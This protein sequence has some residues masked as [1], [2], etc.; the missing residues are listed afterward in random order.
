MASDTITSLTITEK[1]STYANEN[2][3]REYTRFTDTVE[4]PTDIIRTK[5]KEATEKLKRD[6]FISTRLEF[7]SKDSNDRYFIHRRWLANAYGEEVAHGVVTPRD[8]RVWEAD[9]TS[10]VSSA[11]FLQ[12]GR[13]NRLIY[14]IPQE[15]ITVVDSTNGYFKL[16][17]GYPTS[18]RR[19]FVDYWSVGKRLSEIETEL[20]NACCCWATIQLL[21]QYKKTH[22]LKNG[23]VS[24]SQGGRSIQRNESDFDALVRQWYNEYHSKVQW[25]RPQYIRKVKMGGLVE[26]TNSRGYTA[27]KLTYN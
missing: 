7:V 12:G 15:A 16:A 9:E 11:L 27:N 5:L 10:S 26:R 21:T 8:I 6:A 25:L 24:L 19:V 14:E 20:N 3:W 22:R 13:M 4:F 17:D 1:K 18:S 2:D 23:V